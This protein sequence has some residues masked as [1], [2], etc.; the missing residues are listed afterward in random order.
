MSTTLRTRK[1]QKVYR[2]YTDGLDKSECVFCEFT[3]KSKQVIKGLKHF[4]IVTNIYGYDMWDSSGV[5]EHLM[6]VPK[7]HIDSIAEF[8]TEEKREFI[9]NLVA[10]EK[11]GYSIYARSANNSRKSVAHQH[12]HLIKVDNKIKRILFFI[13]KP[14]LMISK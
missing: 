2:N 10:Y 4:W 3:L 9:E 1:S 14:H 12:T 8:N 11:K 6:I 13:K 7:R 5:K